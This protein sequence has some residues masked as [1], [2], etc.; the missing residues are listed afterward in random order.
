MRPALLLA[1]LAALPAAAL[2]AGC[3]SSPMPPDAASLIAKAEAALGSANLKSLVV[4][5]R[6][7]GATF[8][9][10]FQPA[11]PWPGL[12][13]SVLTRAFNFETGALREDFG[14]SRSEPNGGGAVPLMGLGEQRATGFVREGFAWAPGANNSFTPQP[15]AVHAREHD[16]WTATPQGAL[17][18]AKR[19]AA[20]AGTKSVGG[21][22]LNTLAFTAP[23]RFAATVF[24]DAVGLPVR[25]ESTLPHAVAGDTAVVTEFSEYQA[26]GGLRF[27]MKLRQSAGGFPVLDIAYSEV[28]PGEAV[29]IAVPD[30]VRSAR[31]NVTADKVAEGVWFLAGGTHNSVAIELADQI[32]L[33][34]APLYD[35][36]TLAVI[37]RANGLVPG[38]TVKTVV[39]SHHHFDHAGG[40]RAAA[41]E[42][43]LL[44][45]SAIARP[46]F[47]RLFANPNRVAP[48]HLAK[49][50]RTPR[51]LG[52]SGST[53]L[54]DPVRPVEVHELQGSIHAQG[55]LLV[56]LPRERLLIQADAYTPG[57]PGAPP[58]PAPNANHVNLVQN[59]ERLKLDVDR[60]LPLHSRVVPM[61]ELLAQVGRR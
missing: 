37:Q 54:A 38:K 51:L 52:V 28:K 46:Y 18:A 56:W 24:L 30:N 23:G 35:G 32:V 8:G 14:R 3:A 61:S 6:G 19:F 27:P 31:E 48:D 10:A 36:R 57:P 2:V 58:P 20:V 7:T 33:V 47:E 34:E 60:I 41:G 12:N 42:G 40:L 15:V 49:S 29:D 26:V 13:Y 50:G 5:G 39:N 16:L 4:T 22:T 44:V 11:N 53:T 9:Q 59:I 25:I 43:A 1:A 17:M 21:Q 55:F 45:T